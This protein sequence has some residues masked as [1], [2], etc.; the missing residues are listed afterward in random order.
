M[1]KKRLWLTPFFPLVLFC[2]SLVRQKE[3]MEGVAE[4][5]RIALQT[6]FP[7]LFPGLVLSR[8]IVLSFSHTKGAA[9]PSLPFFLGLVCG[10]PIGAKAVSD[11]RREGLISKTDGERMLFFSSGAGPSFVLAVCGISA[12]HSVKLG[13]ILLIL[14]WSLAFFF[15]FLHLQKRNDKSPAKEKK[16]SPLPFS[17]LLSVSLRDALSS[18]LYIL[19]CIVFFSFVIRL[20]LSFLPLSA[21]GGALLHLFTELTGGIARLSALPSE[22]AFPYCAAALGWSSLSVHLQTV[23]ILAE[24]DLSYKSYFAGRAFFSL[25]MGLGASFLQKLL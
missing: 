13:V 5:L 16:L 1:T 14:Q 19:S 4:G 22:R 10:F 8:M 21:E 24:S 11:L 6:A 20:A 23:G 7:A 18:F 3:C 12:L 15:F 25:F 17:R 9:S 2:L